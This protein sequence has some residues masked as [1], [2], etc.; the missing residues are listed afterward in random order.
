MLNYG[1]RLLK[2]LMLGASMVLMV[3][4]TEPPVD[5]AAL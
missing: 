1:A 2:Y 3:A 5:R 4:A